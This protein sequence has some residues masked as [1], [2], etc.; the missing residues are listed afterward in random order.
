[1]GGAESAILA[2]LGSG[3]LDLAVC[4][5]APLVSLAPSINLLDLPFLFPRRAT[6]YASFDGPALAW[7]REVLGAAGLKLLA[8]FDGGERHLAIRPREVRCPADLRGLRL[9][10]LETPVHRAM[11]EAW[12]AIPVHAPSGSLRDQLLDGA[13]DGVERS[14]SNLKDLRLIEAAPH[15]TRVG[16]SVVPAYL[17]AGIRVWAQLSPSERE[18]LAHGAALAAARERDAYVAADA[19][20]LEALRA[21]GIDP[22]EGDREAFRESSAPVWA[23]YRTH[24]G[25]AEGLQRIEVAATPCG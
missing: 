6:A 10:T 8:I 15:V 20:A 24:L 22:V 21:G 4:T 16:H 2:A 18:L 17:L 9:R 19:E 11:L 12:G 14:W 3:E 7:G 23:T 1:M 5:S 25:F 13:L